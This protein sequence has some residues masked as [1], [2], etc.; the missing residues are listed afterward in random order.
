MSEAYRKLEILVDKLVP[1]SLAFV[2]LHFILLFIIPDILHDYENIILFLEV[3]L[4]TAVLGL[5]VTFKFRRAK[6]KK[7]FLKHHWLEVIAIFPFMVI[8]RLFE[9][10]YLITRLAPL[11]GVVTDTQ[12]IL[13][14][15]RGADAATDIVREAQFAGRAPRIGMFNKIFRPLTRTPRFLRGSAFYEHPLTEKNKKHH[16]IHYLFYS[17]HAK[18]VK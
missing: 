16:K 2:I 4:V 7:D 11:E 12:T 1:Y 13:H 6:D 18:N 10:F 9:E 17:K 14:E 5:D 15:L 8:F 3:F